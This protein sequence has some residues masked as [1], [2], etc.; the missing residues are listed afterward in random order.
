MHNSPLYKRL[1]FRLLGL[2]YGFTYWT[3][4]H[5][6]LGFRIRTLVILLAFAP[7]FMVWRRSKDGVIVGLAALLGLGTL[8][9]YWRARRVGYMRFVAGETAVTATDHLEPLPPNQ[10]IALKASGLFGVSN[11]EEQVLLCPANYWRV[12]LGDHTV[13][14]QPERGRFLYQFFSAPNLQNLQHGW[15]IHGLT[16]HSVLAVTFFSDWGKDTISLRELY[17]GSDEASRDKKRRAIYLCFEDEEDK[18]AVW[19]TILFDA[20]EKRKTEI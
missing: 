5:K 9:L 6:F 7:L 11:R 18:Q 8:W 14:A 13:M 20:R 2:V 16:L 19:H 1:Y 4:Q 10:R 17:Q 15:L 3:S 12:P